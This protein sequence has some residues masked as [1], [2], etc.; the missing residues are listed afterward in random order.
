MKKR[1]IKLSENQF[2]E[3]I[4][5]LVEANRTAKKEEAIEYN[6]MIYYIK[7]D[8]IKFFITDYPEKLN[9]RS[10]FDGD[11]KL[12]HIMINNVIFHVP[13]GVKYGLKFEDYELIEYIKDFDKDLTCLYKPEEIFKKL[14]E[15]YVYLNKGINNIKSGVIKYWYVNYIYQ[16]INNNS[17]IKRENGKQSNNPGLNT[18]YCLFIN[19]EIVEKKLFSEFWDITANKY[20]EYFKIIENE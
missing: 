9:I 7:H 4:T 18:E 2:K 14:F 17:E 20:K 3:L 5:I 15:Y 12:F 8:I 6:N 16:Q 19:N 11:H 1:N 13:F 10:C